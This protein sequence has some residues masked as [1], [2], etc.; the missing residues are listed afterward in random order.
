MHSVHPQ[1]SLLL[2]G[3]LFV[4]LAFFDGPEPNAHPCRYTVPLLAVPGPPSHQGSLPP[5]ALEQMYCAIALLD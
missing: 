2:S 3:F 1:H 5:M 4:I